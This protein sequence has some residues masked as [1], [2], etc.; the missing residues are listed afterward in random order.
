MA[1]SWMLVLQEQEWLRF[2]EKCS[3]AHRQVDTQPTKWSKSNNDKSAVALLKKDDWHERESVANGHHDSSGKLIAN[4]A[5]S[6]DEIHRNV[7]YLM[8]DNWVAYFRTWR[9]RSLFSGR[10]LTC[11]SQSSVWSSRKLLRVI[12]KFETKIFSRLYLSRW[13]SWA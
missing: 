7:N 11:R 4:V 13:T 12:L 9:R 1:S 6:W 10:A 5:K 3:F 8:H 2:G